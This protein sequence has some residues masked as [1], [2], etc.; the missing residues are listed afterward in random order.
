MNRTTHIFTMIAFAVVC[1]IAWAGGWLAWPEGAASPREVRWLA[2]GV[3]V[4]F[5]ATMPR[6]VR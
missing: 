2:A 1:V 6:A 4:G 5:L 3:I